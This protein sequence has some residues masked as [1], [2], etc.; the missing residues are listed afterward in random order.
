MP[1]K[2]VKFEDWCN[3]CKYFPC[4]PGKNDNP[5]NNCL[6]IPVNVDSKRPIFWNGDEEYAKRKERKKKYDPNSIIQQL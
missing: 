6:S 1:D 5:C 4:D 3:S 2:I